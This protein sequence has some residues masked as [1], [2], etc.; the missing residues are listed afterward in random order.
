MPDPLDPQQDAVY[1]AQREVFAD[2]KEERS[3]VELQAFVN[4]FVSEPWFRARYPHLK[5]VD[6]KDGRGASDALSGS[7]GRSMLLPRGTRYQFIAVHETGHLVDVSGGE[8]HG[9]VFCGLFLFMVGK[10]YDLKRKSRLALRFRKYDVRWDHKIAK[11]G[12][13]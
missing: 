7:D 5:S 8:D 6:V 10:V 13:P 4:D 12:R 1:R 3:V 2:E 9:A 11:Y